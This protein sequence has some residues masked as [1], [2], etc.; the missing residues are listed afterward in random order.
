MIRIDQLLTSRGFAK[1]RTHAQDLINSYRVFIFTYDKKILVKK[2]SLLV[3]EETQ[4]IVEQSTTDEFV[5]RAGIKLNGALNH[6]QMSVE[7]LNVL[8]VGCSTGGFSDC[9][10]KR[11]ANFVLGVDV[12]HNQ[13]DK[14]LLTN[15]KFKLIEGLNARALNANPEFLSINKLH[16]FDL[17]V[18]D[19]SFISITLIIPEIS[20]LLASGKQLLSLVKPQFEVGPAH[21]VNGIV[22]NSSLFKEVENKIFHCLNINNFEVLNYFESSI[23]GKDGNKE[24]FVYAQKK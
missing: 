5:S 11:S 3:D 15:S 23:E 10:L 4:I 9:L 18:M 7:N 16:P 21:L 2:S 24:F 22:K 13:I 19:V 17:V 1:S 6:L 14:N 20:K 12:G 8:D